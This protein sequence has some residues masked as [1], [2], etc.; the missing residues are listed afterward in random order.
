MSEPRVPRDPLASLQHAGPQGVIWAD[1]SPDLGES[2]FAFLLVLMNLLTPAPTQPMLAE[3]PTIYPPEIVAD[4]VI[5]DIV[6]YARYTALSEFLA[7]VA[8]EDARNAAE[9]AERAQRAAQAQRPVTT[10]QAPS[11]ASGDCYSG[12]PVP[13]WII[14][15][16]SG[17]DPN[18]V[19]PS[20]GAYG[21]YQL[22]PM[23]YNGGVCS[24]LGRDLAGQKA[25]AQRLYDRAGLAPWAL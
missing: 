16:E 2:L 19:N 12:T 18:A 8:A 13:P 6:S 20:S 23:H 10:P 24:D 21:C 4:R 7:A 15:R 9:A 25:C 3:R 17:G 5:H 11:G 1:L 22:M 14:D